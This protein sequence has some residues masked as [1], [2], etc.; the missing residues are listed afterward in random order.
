M[1]SDLR[2]GFTLIELLV[3]I[4]I[5]AILAAI[6]FP[7]FAQAREKARG[8]S[9]ISNLKQESLATLQYV[10]DY[11]ETYPMAFG[12]S[13]KYG[14][15]TTGTQRP[16]PPDQFADADVWAQSYSN[17]IQSY[18]KNYGVYTC[19]DSTVKN[20]GY[21]G[22]NTIVKISYTYNGLLQSCPMAGITSPAGLIM[23]HAGRGRAYR[24]NADLAQPV[25]SCGDSTDLSCRYKA[26]LADGTCAKGN[27]AG[28]GWYGSTDGMAIH[29]RGQSMAYADGH[30]K[31][32]NLSLSTIDPL[33]TDGNQDPWRSYDKDGNIASAYGDGCH[34]YLFRP[35]MNF[36]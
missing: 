35:D 1:R 18:V 33:T 9:C 36:Q 21:T 10:Q 27:G 2:R 16:V 4:A 15:W 29:G 23:L 11:D 3:V 6:L 26:K 28:S 20:G 30:A 24:L 34:I 14:G 32:R 7:V 31:N 19:P 12:Y 22:L 8:I 25:L 17:A 5:I 13:A